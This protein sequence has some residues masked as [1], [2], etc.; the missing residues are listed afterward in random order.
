MNFQEINFDGL[1]GPTHNYAGLAM[2]NLASAR[3]AGGV[4]NPRAAA[5][6]G[7]AKMRAVRSLGLTQGFL[8][9]LDRPHMKTLRA[10][11]FAG[12]DRA[13]IE[14][15][16][17]AAP[18]LLANVY[19]ASSMWTA[20]AGT[21]S[22]SPD[23]ADGKVHVTPANLAGNF[24]RSI[25]PQTTARVLAH[26]FADTAHFTHHQILPGGVHFGDE[27]AA[28][29]GRLAPAHGE[30]G[31]ELFVYGEDGARFP[32]RQKRRAS[33]A[34]ARA[35]R[36]HPERTLFIQQSRAALDAGAFHN[37]V[38]GVAN[39]AVLFLHE[40]SFED[41]EGAYAAIR[42]AA[43][44]VEIIEAPREEVTLDDAISSYLFNSQL[45]SLKG[46]EM[47]LIL[48]KESEE[49]ARVKAF[50]EKTVAANNPVNRALYYD[51]RESMRNGGGPACLRLRVVLS[52]AERAAMNQNF[53]ADDARLDA[54]EAWVTRHY[55]DRLA[56]EDLKDPRLMEESFAAMDA[57]TQL[58]GMGAFYDFQR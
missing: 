41:R 32:A 56:V 54:L 10:L 26:I 28:N 55:R 31:V 58:L 15:C 13:I 39:G 24:H 37:D 45:L 27:G 18:Q 50:I 23:T 1:I 6:Q 2:G 35:H 44:F 12:T 48:P 19:S 21:I 22:P 49:N 30:P 7:L 29:H 43:P 8:P 57:L 16:A 46:G 5:L 34:V 51:V 36:L 11:G 42:A 47:A 4:S 53:L 9:P 25:E 14:A 38:V 3:N 33:E 20:N 40:Q 52:E 17:K